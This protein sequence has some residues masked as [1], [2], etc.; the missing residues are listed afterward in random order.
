MDFDIRYQDYTFKHSLSGQPDLTAARFQEHYHTTWE[1]LYFVRGNADFMLQ[2]QLYKIKPGSMLIA[3]PGEYHHI[4]F[5]T[6]EPYERFV[7]RFNAQTLHRHVR[8]Q[9]EKAESVYFIEHSPLAS[10][11]W[12][13]DAHVP[14]VHPDVQLSVCIGSLH[15]LLAYLI[16]SQNLIQKADYI[17]EDAHRVAEHIERHLAEIHS[18]EDIAASLHMSRTSIYRLFSLQFQTPVMNYVRTQ[19]CIA[20]RELLQQGISPLDAAERLGY[21]HYSSFYRDYRKTFG[22]TPSAEAVRED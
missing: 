12:Q 20:A 1:F 14:R 6:V 5:H 9:L 2:H 15:I 13:L 19:K 3:K 4:L 7:V 10:V 11:F 16:S 17:N 21:S 22:L 18:A 8:R